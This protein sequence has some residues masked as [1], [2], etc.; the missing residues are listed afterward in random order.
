[1]DQLKLL[2]KLATI[3]GPLTTLANIGMICNQHQVCSILQMISKM[4]VFLRMGKWKL[5]VNLQLS[6]KD[7]L[8]YDLENDPNETTNVLDDNPEVF[9]EMLE[10]Y[11][12]S[13]V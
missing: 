9:Q 1:L 7:Y 11:N 6:F 10:R 4:T 13:L 8:L 5:G 12:V 2:L 3:F